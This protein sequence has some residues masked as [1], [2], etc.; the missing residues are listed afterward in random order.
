MNPIVTVAY[1]DVTQGDS[2]HNSQA[3]HPSAA[4]NAVRSIERRGDQV[5]LDCGVFVQWG[6]ADEGIAV[7][8][9]FDLYAL[10]RSEALAGTPR[11]HT[12]SEYLAG[13]AYGLTEPF[14]AP[15]SSTASASEAFEGRS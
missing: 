13:Y 15:S 11:S 2:I 10:G 9:P 4:W 12:E 5:G 3:Y 8:R 14:A 1:K 6:H 7:R